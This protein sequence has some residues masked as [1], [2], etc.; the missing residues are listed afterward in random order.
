MLPKPLGQLKKLELIE[1]LNV[2]TNIAT[3]G[4]SVPQLRTALKNF[5]QEQK[6]IKAG[7]W[8]ADESWNGFQPGL[9][10][11]HPGELPRVARN[12]LWEP[13][14]G[15][16]DYLAQNSTP[17][18]L[19]HLALPEQTLQEI[20][21]WSNEYAKALHDSPAPSWYHGKS[22]PT[23]WVRGI[24]SKPLSLLEFKQVIAL[25]QIMGVLPLPQRK[26]YWSIGFIPLFPG[27]QFGQVMSRD[28]F[29]AI[30]SC[31]T[32]CDRTREH[33]LK[34]KFPKT[35]SYWKVGDFFENFV[36][37]IGS[38]IDPGEYVTLDEVVIKSWTP[39]QL[40]KRLK[41]KPA[42]SGCMLAS[43][44]TIDGLLL[45]LNFP[46]AKQPPPAGTNATSQMVQHLISTLPKGTKVAADN[47]FNFVELSRTLYESGYHIFGT[48]RPDRIP[49][50]VQK[51]FGSLKQKE[52]WSFLSAHHGAV[53]LFGWT[54]SKLCFFVSNLPH[55]DE[56]KVKRWDRTQGVRRDVSSFFVARKFN[57]TKSGADTNDLMV[58][59]Y[60]SHHPSRKW[61]R[62]WSSWVFD[63]ARVWAYLL[64]KR[65]VPGLKDMTHLQ[66]ISSITR[67][68]LGDAII[69]PIERDRFASSSTPRKR[70]KKEADAAPNNPHLC[71]ILDTRSLDHGDPLFRRRRNCALCWMRNQYQHKV[72][73]F[74]CE[75]GCGV[76]LCLEFRHHVDYHVNV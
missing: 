45:R 38:Y 61:T 35:G 63:Q 47:Y 15:L 70:L 60:S 62:S 53:Y 72:Q 71:K 24:K 17:L 73:T 51:Y 74:C 65:V 6:Q 5:M 2:H 33:E 44:H 52:K 41:F 23:S 16:Q 69:E 59:N 4:L 40:N 66:F 26:F 3:A 19:F 34:A 32:F 50:G 12:T 42:G 58:A 46:R 1:V 68:L 22:W 21:E 9:N 11:E 56:S 30:S 8:I 48:M 25:S 43:L 7:E 55:V 39:N 75:P 20:V 14:Q 57:E 54:D 37:R 64:G 29:L 13:T 49:T 10:P 31:L 27:T 67:G 28:R 18:D 76:F 36:L